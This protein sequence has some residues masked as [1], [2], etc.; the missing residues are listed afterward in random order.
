MTSPLVR[1]VG[2]WWRRPVG[3]GVGVPSDQAAEPAQ[4]HQVPTRQD[5]HRMHD[6]VTTD[7]SDERQQSSRRR[8]PAAIGG[9][10]A[11]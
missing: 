6:P 3:F 7:D 10:A 1:A 8:D 4:H 2:L 5:V 9:R 11:K